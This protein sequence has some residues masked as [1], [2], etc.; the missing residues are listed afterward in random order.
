VFLM[1]IGTSPGVFPEGL[2]VGLRVIDS[3]S[4]D[5]ELVSP[6][7]TKDFATLQL[8]VRETK[9]SKTAFSERTTCNK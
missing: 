5:Q 8:Y 6:P 1:N 4:Q 3:K 7:L 2:D 9:N